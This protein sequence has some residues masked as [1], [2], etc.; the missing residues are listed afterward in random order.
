MS[1]AK[2]RVSVPLMPA[3]EE[4]PEPKASAGGITANTRLPARCPTSA[5]ARPGRI[6]PTNSDG[7]PEL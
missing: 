4:P 3:W 5:F 6:W 2:T 7:D 1:T